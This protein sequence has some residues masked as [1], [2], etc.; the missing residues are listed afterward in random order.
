VIVGGGFIGI[1][2]AEQLHAAGVQVTIVEMLDQI[3]PNY[4]KEMVVPAMKLMISKGVKLMLQSQCKQ[5]KEENNKIICLVGENTE[6]AADFVVLAIGVRP[7]NQLAKDAGLQLG[8]RGGVLVN[9]HMQT[10]DPD[11]YAVGDCIEVKDFV[12]G[13]NTYIPLAGPAN[14]QGRIAADHIFNKSPNSFRG[15]Q[16]SNILRCFDLAIASTG[17]SEKILKRYNI[18]YLKVYSHHGDHASYYPGAERMT[19]KLLFAP[20]TG[21]ILGCQV[22]GKAGVD[23]RVD[24]ISIAIQAG[25]T[26]FD[27][28]EAELC[29][30]PQYGSAKDPVNMLGFIASGV[31]RGDQQLC[32]LDDILDEKSELAKESFIIDVRTPKEFEGGPIVPKAVNIPLEQLRS[33]VNEIPKEA[34]NIVT[35]CRIGMRG[36]LAQRLLE[37]MGYK[38]VKNIS[39]GWELFEKTKCGDPSSNV[40]Q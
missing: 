31:L 39:G 30:S 18:P 10:S 14:R 4:D 15:T 37:E 20:K 17:A 40:K 6:V 11:V 28:E 1:E 9:E 27:L 21:K 8:N 19:L 33:R 36:Y 26:V 22:I 3:L 7:D 13:N 24:V 29:Y 23:K 35:Y 38:S 12:I 16:G 34:K 5:F 25:M 32:Y 2:L